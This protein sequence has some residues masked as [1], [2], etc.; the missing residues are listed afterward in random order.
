[1]IDSFLQFFKE[2]CG[3]ASVHLCMMELERDGKRGLQPALAIAA[4]GE[5]RIGEDAVLLVDDAVKLST[6]HCRRADYHS[7]II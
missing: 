7:L 3:M 5:E 4:P 2:V 1:M 6:S